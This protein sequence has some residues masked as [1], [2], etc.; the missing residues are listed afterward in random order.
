MALLSSKKRF[1]QKIS[2]AI[3]TY[4]EEKKIEQCLQSLL[5]IVDEL[6]VVDS[7]STDN[8]KAICQ[9]YNIKFIEQPFLGYIEQKNFAIN[10]TKYKYVLSLDADEVLSQQLQQSI[11]KAKQKGLLF[12]VYSMNR[13]TTFCGKFIKHGSWYPDTK[14]RLFNKEK[15]KWA[16][17]NPHDKIEYITG[18]SIK[19]LQGDILHYSYNTLEEVI[20][21]ANKFTTIQAQAMYYKGKRATWL[22]LIINPMV[23]FFSGY[24]IKRGFLDGKDGFILANI[25]AWQ[26]LL[27]YAKLLHLQN[28]KM[29]ALT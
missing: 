22:H 18:C 26:T 12:D 29:K 21:Q 7:C 13:C 19:K 28:K 1:M 6:V 3:I 14:V 4:N 8:T 15:A 16:G 10:Q 25:I 9:Q 2:A 17:T 23:A 27:K 24:F 5:P 11:L 20:E